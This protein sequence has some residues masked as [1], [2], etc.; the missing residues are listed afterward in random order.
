MALTDTFVRQVKH[1]G[2]SAGDKY[3]DGEGMF[4]LVKATGKY[5]RMGYRFDGKQ[6]ALAFGVY[7][8]VSLAQARR[9]RDEARKA[10][11]VGI[12]PSRAK[13]DAKAAKEA[14]M[15]NTFEALARE[16]LQK[17]SKSRSASTQEKVTA[18][19]EHD[20]FPFVGNMPGYGTRTQQ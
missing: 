12:D 11:A 1:S 18:W 17:V 4:L 5:W 15:A 14:E 20:V 6:K 7:P 10:L 9:R 2:A 16:W 13:S 8:A 19:L 3:S